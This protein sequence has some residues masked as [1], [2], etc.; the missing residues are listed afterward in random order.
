[1]APFLPTLRRAK[2]ISAPKARLGI[3]GTAGT[4]EE[5]EGETTVAADPTF[6]TGEGGNLLRMD[7]LRPRGRRN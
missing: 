7:C 5:E 4:G 2:A 6:R 1:M 3:Y